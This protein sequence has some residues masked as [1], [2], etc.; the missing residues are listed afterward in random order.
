MLKKPLKF[1]ALLAVT[2]VGAVLGLAS[3]PVPA[4]A[5]DSLDEEQEKAI[6][7]A[8]KVA[9]SAAV[10]IET[11]GGV[12]VVRAGRAAVRRGIGPTT[13]VI[14]SDDGYVI[15][16]SFNFANKPATIRVTIPGQKPRVARVVAH[17]ETRML[18]LLKVNLPQGT[19]LPVPKPTPKK[20]MEIGLMAV[21]LGRTLSAEDGPPSVSVGIISATDRIWGKAVQTDAKISPTNYG[22]P[23]IDIEGRVLGVL[24]PASPQADGALAGFEWYDSGIGFAI[25][26]DDINAVLP[27]LKKGT[28]K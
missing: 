9:A 8:V 28:E 22:G 16:S 11:S 14:V 1:W 20:D 23:L 6:K 12:E 19:K 3:V 13:G 15:S 10:K 7:A 18:T 2:G 26:L 25:P 4:K 24:V 17:D 27:R 21:A 5:D